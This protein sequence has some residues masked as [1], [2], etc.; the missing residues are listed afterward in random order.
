MI[1]MVGTTNAV[2]LT[3][4]LDGLVS[5]LLIIVGLAFAVISYVSGHVLS[6]PST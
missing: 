3:D 1:L 6:W 2:N 4:G 5:G